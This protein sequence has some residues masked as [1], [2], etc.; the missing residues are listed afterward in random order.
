MTKKI[1]TRESLEQAQMSLHWRYAI[2]VLDSWWED[3]RERS[4]E[5]ICFGA[6]ISDTILGVDSM[7]WILKHKIPK[8]IVYERYEMTTNQYYSKRVKEA[9]KKNKKFKEYNLYHFFTYFNWKQWN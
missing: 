7:Q 6:D 3:R 9:I 8:D 1:D 2:A 5:P 4:I